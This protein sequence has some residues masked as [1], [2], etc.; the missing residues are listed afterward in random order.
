MAPTATDGPARMRAL[1]AGLPDALLDGYRRGRELAVPA[2][3]GPATIVTAGMGGSGIAAEL[4]RG[5]VE[6][7]TSLSFVLARS[8]PSPTSLGSRSRVLLMSYSGNTWETLRAYDA[9]GAAGAFRVAITSGGALAEKAARDRV[10]LLPVP[11]GLPPRSAVGHLMGGLLGLL[12][13]W[14]PESNEARLSRI[15]EH[16]RPVVAAHA[17]ARGP[18]AKL[19]EQVGSRLPFVYAESG[20]AGLARR[21]KTQ[22]EENAKRLALFDEVPELMHNAIVAWDALPRADARRY[23]V[24]SLEWTGSTPLVRQSQQYLDKLLRGRG[25]TVVPV[26]LSSEDRLEALVHGLSLGDHL[27][28]FL[29]ERGRID[30]Y[31]VDAITRLKT[32]LGTTGPAPPSGR[33]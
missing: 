3:R 21:W 28:L 22:V 2:E 12:D 17:R 25:V 11:P 7:E 27:S 26:P 24:L 13:P 18:A 31:P 9:A 16:V 10:P 29:A 20:F 15:V 4:A 6:A 5:V 14:F 19:A 30:P 8:P 32:A 23:A 1:A 33:K